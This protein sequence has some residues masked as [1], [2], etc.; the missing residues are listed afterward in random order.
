MANQFGLPDSNYGSGYGSTWGTSNGLSA[1]SASGGGSM[2]WITAG[3]SILGSLGASGAAK[4][5]A[6]LDFK[7]QQKLNEQGGVISRQNSQFDAQ[8]NYYYHQLDRQE[9]MRG[10][11]EFRKFS[12]VKDYAPDYTNT[13]PAPLNTAVMPAYNAGAYA[14]APIK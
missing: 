10:L 9:K 8:Q 11:D 14:P 2:A 12:T 6:K 5:K 13:N 7:N 4:K 1:A 3:A